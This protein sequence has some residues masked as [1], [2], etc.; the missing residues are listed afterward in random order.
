M[1]TEDILATRF[2]NISGTIFTSV[3]TEKTT[4]ARIPKPTG[5]KPGSQNEAAENDYSIAPIIGSAVGTLFACVVA[6]LAAVLGDFWIWRSKRELARSQALTSSVPEPTT[7]TP[8]LNGAPVDDAALEAGTNERGEGNIDGIAPGQGHVVMFSSPLTIPFN[9]DAEDNQG[10][11]KD[12]NEDPKEDEG[13]DD[14]DDEVDDDVDANNQAQDEFSAQRNVGGVQILHPGHLMLRWTVS[15]VER[16][17][18]NIGIRDAVIRIFV[19]RQIDGPKL[20]A[21]TDADLEH[22]LGIES[23]NA[24]LA[25]LR[26]VREAVRRPDAV[27][28]RPHDGLDGDLPPGIEDGQRD[29][30]QP[31]PYAR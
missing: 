7:A 21:L 22:D 24:R 1:T 13:E 26:S 28:P 2:L 30:D 14:G 23:R 25:L 12:V 5:D 8:A 11:Q 20:V 16:W 29:G 19:E 4:R 18:D 15:D 31:P 17:L 6:I 3:E 10:F 9:N 27:L